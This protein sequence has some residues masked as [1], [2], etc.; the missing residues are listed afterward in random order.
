[1]LTCRASSFLHRFTT[2]LP[3][4]VQ[5]LFAAVSPPMKMCNLC[6]MGKVCFALTMSIV[7]C[8]NRSCACLKMKCIY[9]YIHRV[10]Q[11][12]GISLRC[13]KIASFIENMINKQ[14]IWG[15]YIFRHP[16][17]VCCL[18]YWAVCFSHCGSI[19][20]LDQL[21]LLFRSFA[22]TCEI[23]VLYVVPG[24]ILL[25][26]SPFI[27][28]WNSALVPSCRLRRAECAKIMEKC[29]MVTTRSFHFKQ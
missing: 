1:M 14:W 3:L 20:Q 16:Y 18:L 7:M 25:L 11:Y 15:Y 4:G 2:Y 26:I 27:S 13:L 6:L 23:M 10:Y 12:I 28:V 24:E 8:S 21:V 19:H 17:M 22:S 5:D 29:A 9:I